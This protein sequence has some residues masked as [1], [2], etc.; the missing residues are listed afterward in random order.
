[1]S[2]G[3]RIF[4]DHSPRFA[5][6]AGLVFFLIVLTLA[7]RIFSPSDIVSRDQSRTV[8][9][10]IDIVR[11]SNLLLASDADGFPATKPPLINYLSAL[12]VAPFG[13]NEWTFMFPSLLA[14]FAT[15]ALV[16][17][18]ARDVFAEM[19]ERPG[20]LGLTA[21]EWATLLAV[22]FYGLSAMAL[23][24][25]FVARPD[26]IL[27]FFLTLSFYAANRAL[28]AKPPAGA[29]WVF[30]FW[31]AAI[32]AALAKG[33][34]ALIPVIYAM[35]AAKL[36]HG[37]WDAVHRLRPYVGAPIAILVALAWPVAVYLLA[38]EHFR[39][40]LLNQELGGQFEGAWYSGV[41]SAWQV[42]LWVI[43]RFMPWSLL[44]LVGAWFFPWRQWRTH[45]LAPTFLYILLLAIPFIL[46]ASRRGDRFAP[47]F[48]LVAVVCAWAA[49]YAW[50]GQAL[51]RTSVAAIPAVI[52]GLTVYFYFLSDQAKDLSGQ[53]MLDFVREV[54]AKAADGRPLLFCK[55]QNRGLA[56]QAFLGVNQRGRYAH[57]APEGG[58]WVISEGPGDQPDALIESEPIPLIEGRRLYVAPAEA[59][60]AICKGSRDRVE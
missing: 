4:A 41:I 53:R 18:M 9:Y 16:Y 57:E 24:L 47:F 43:S 2:P 55:T 58:A 22:G 38:P 46:V 23:R 1:M 11:N 28:A 39:N 56:L 36:F 5:L 37:G 40:I 33:P 25:A 20:W 30:V 13:A 26:M 44:L 59:G 50:R 49:V 31:L 48:P 52:V 27:V 19:P 34:I 15:L 60:N 32:L 45:P 35:L 10:T 6:A 12:L 3:S 51:L 7:L 42:P 29:G 8:S 17:L 14:F 21:A 54:K